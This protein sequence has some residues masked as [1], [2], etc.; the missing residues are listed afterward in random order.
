MSGPKDWARR[1]QEMEGDP[2]V[3][4]APPC[5]QSKDDVS[6]ACP[7]CG[8]HWHGGSPC[9]KFNAQTVAETSNPHND[10]RAAAQALIDGQEPTVGQMVTIMNTGADE[11]ERLQRELRVMHADRRSFLD[12][13]NTIARGGPVASM[14]EHGSAAL[15]TKTLKRLGLIAW[16][17]K[18]EAAGRTP[19]AQWCGDEATCTVARDADED[20][21]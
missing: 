11:I 10:L 16:S 20:K 18:D 12:T 14:P 19:C 21:V 13:L 4:D 3:P 6:I 1:D 9:T 17:C 5:H 2:G 8:G 15:A 7:R